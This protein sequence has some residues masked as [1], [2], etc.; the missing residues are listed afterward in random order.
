MRN[1]ALFI[2]RDGILNKVVIRDGVVGSPRHISEFE[3]IA[4][5][6]DMVRAARDLGYLTVV[7]TNQPDIGRKKMGVAELVRM[8]DAVSRELSPDFINVCTSCDDG[9][10]RRKPNPGMLL[11]AMEAFAIN[12]AGSFLL[13]DGEKDML[14]GE[15]AGVQTILLKTGYNAAVHGR[16]GLCVDSLAEVVSLLKTAAGEEG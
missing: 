6:G 13:G 9:D 7:V 10:F 3:M 14:A 2:D 16:A 5:A 8:H 15:R 4:T 11:E 1:K 12:P